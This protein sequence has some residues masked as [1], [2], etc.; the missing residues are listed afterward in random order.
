MLAPRTSLNTEQNKCF[1]KKH[2]PPYGFL[3]TRKTRPSLGL[4]PKM[5]ED[6]SDVRPNR[7][8]KFTPIGKAPRPRHQG[9]AHGGRAPAKIVRALAKI[10][11]LFMLKIEKDQMTT[12]CVPW[13]LE[14]TAESHSLLS[15]LSRA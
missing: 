8:A 3:L 7:R 15:R 13:K 5:G 6:L 9:G 12:L 11:G 4:S 1:S 14:Q 2:I 10:T